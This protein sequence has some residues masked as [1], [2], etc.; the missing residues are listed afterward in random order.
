MKRFLI[1]AAIVAVVLGL[2]VG[3]RRWIHHAQLELVPVLIVPGEDAHTIVDPPPGAIAT[4][5]MLDLREI[6]SRPS[7]P[8]LAVLTFDDGPYPVETPALADELA[9]LH[10]PAEFFLIGRDALQQ[11]AIARRLGSGGNETGNHSMTHP[12]MSSLAY[13]AQ[14]AEIE[15]GAVAVS[16]TT[17]QRV[18]YFRPPH[19]NY[20]ENTIKAALDLRETVALWNDDPGDWRTLS[21]DAIAKLAVEQ[22]RAPVVILLH[23]GKD[24]TIGALP[25]IVGAFRRAGY[26]FVTLSELQREVPVDEINDPIRVTL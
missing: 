3:L 4:R 2:V 7:R 5:M 25:A 21:P 18:V 22:A 20:D 13:D 19:G 12:E 10:L 23:D 16:A 8:R 1:A 15:Q 14:R 26:R 9:R 11:P 17:G 24:S 6:V